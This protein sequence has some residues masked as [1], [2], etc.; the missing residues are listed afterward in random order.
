[1]LDR[2]ENNLQPT[3]K[4]YVSTEWRSLP[5]FGDTLFV[6]TT[7]KIVGSTV[8]DTHLGHRGCQML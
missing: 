8:V 5:L 2:L 7:N 4:Y 3:T 1:M 6:T